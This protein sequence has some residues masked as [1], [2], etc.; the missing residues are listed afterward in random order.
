MKTLIAMAFFWGV[1]GSPGEVRAG[2]VQQQTPAGTTLRHFGRVDEG[3]YKGSKPK[4]DADYQF[5][6]SLHVKYIVN[7][8]VL[9]LL[10]QPEKT[11]A[12]RYGIAMIPAQMN[13]SPLPPTEKHVVS[14]L[15][16]LRDKRYHPIYFHCALGRDRTSLIATLYKMYFLGMPRQEAERYLY[17]SGYKDGWVR[18]GLTRYLEKHPTRPPGLRSHP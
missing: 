15:A 10:S 5:L 16:M 4:S 13:A 14:I 8:E 2:T 18:S 11:K 12:R 1:S 17:E 3:V 6:R 9:P 7:L